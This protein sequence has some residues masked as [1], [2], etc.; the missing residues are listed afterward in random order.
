MYLK[1]S[2]VPGKRN[3]DRL[4]VLKTYFLNKSFCMLMLY[5]C[6]FQVVC[7]QAFDRYKLETQSYFSFGVGL[8]SYFGD[9]QNN[10]LSPNQAINAELVHRLSPRL[11]VSESLT[12]FRL[13]ADD[14]RQKDPALRERNLSFTSWNLELTLRMQLHLFKTWSHWLRPTSNFYFFSG[15]GA[16]TINPLTTLNG[17]KYRL[18]PWATEG[19]KYAGVALVWPIGLGV[20]FSISRD[21]SIVVEMGYHFT[22]SDYIDDVSTQYYLPDHIDETFKR[23]ADRSYELNLPNKRTGQIRGNPMNNDG[24]TMTVIKLQWPLHKP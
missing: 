13:N 3:R 1:S 18:R 4:M 23:L 10:S 6:A 11:K 5:W 20:Q 17:R 15:L 7:A 24:Y 2:Q 8:T 19:E 22:T 14:S 12:Y 9:L 16:V 21:I